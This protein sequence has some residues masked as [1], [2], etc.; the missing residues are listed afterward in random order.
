MR[1]INY[2]KDECE[3]NFSDAFVMITIRITNSPAKGNAVNKAAKTRRQMKGD[4]SFVLLP[5]SKTKLSKDFEDVV[6]PI[7]RN[8]KDGL[9]HT[10]VG[11]CIVP[12]RN[13]AVGKLIQPYVDNGGASLVFVCSKLSAKLSTSTARAM[14]VATMNIK[15]TMKLLRHN[16]NMQ[17]PRIADE[18]IGI[19]MR[20]KESEKK[21]QRSGKKT[22][23]SMNRKTQEQKSKDSIKKRRLQ[24]EREKRLRALREEERL[25]D[26]KKEMRKLWMPEMPSVAHEKIED[27]PVVHRNTFAPILNSQM[28]TK[29]ILEADA[30]DM[31]VTFQPKVE[32]IEP[33]KAMDIDDSAKLE[34]EDVDIFEELER[35]QKEDEWATFKEKLNLTNWVEDIVL[36]RFQN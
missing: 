7:R 20:K 5:G 31:A 16:D 10:R 36:E 11:A 29:P 17:T 30:I 32:K 12:Y 14:A 19:D 25:R 15:R 13:S 1:L 6:L 27:T 4:L 2:I 26:R 23:G 34:E 35:Q 9:P 3:Q 33:Q 18:S 8:T 22:M 28:M 21:K 24:L